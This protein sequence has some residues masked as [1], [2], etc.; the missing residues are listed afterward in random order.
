MRQMLIYWPMLLLLLGFVA[1]GETVP[2]SPLLVVGKAVDIK[3]I[4]KEQ[5]RSPDKSTS[6]ETRVDTGDELAMVISAVT[7][8]QPKPRNE[9]FLV[10]KPDDIDE[11]VGELAAE[12]LAPVEVVTTLD[13]IEGE[14]PEKPFTEQD[15]NDV[16]NNIIWKIQSEVARN[17]LSRELNM[18]FNSPQCSRACGV[19]TQR[20]P[21]E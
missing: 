12:K 14:V 2:S 10:I 4:S 1:C 16:I 7:P 15:T 17:E 9:P 18:H 20:A 6:I 13:V 21:R 5:N 3:A 11:V 19:P 8:P